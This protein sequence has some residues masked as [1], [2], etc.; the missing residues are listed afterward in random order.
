MV[1]IQYIYINVDIH[2]VLLYIFFGYKHILWGMAFLH[3][4]IEKKKKKDVHIYV[5]FNKC[6][7]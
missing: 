6:D 5:W 3:E 7:I 1:Q 2:S 4:I